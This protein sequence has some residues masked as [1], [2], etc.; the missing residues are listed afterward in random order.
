MKYM[1][2]GPVL[3]A[4]MAQLGYDPTIDAVPQRFR[5]QAAFEVR[6]ALKKLY[7]E[8]LPVLQRIERRQYRPGWSASLEWSH[9]QECWYN[10]EYWRL[11]STVDGSG[12]TEP[13]EAEGNPWTKLDMADVVPYIQFDQAWEDTEMD[14]AGVDVDDFAF[15]GDPK[16]FP[17]AAPIRGIKWMTGGVVLP[18][19]S[20]K[21]VFVKFVPRPPRVSFTE[22]SSSCPYAAGTVVYVTADK[23]CYCA[24]EDIDE[25][26]VTP[27][28]ADAGLWETVRVPEDFEEY[29]AVAAAAAMQTNDQGR[30][31]TLARADALF[32]RIV[33]RF[34]AGIGASKVKTGS[35]G[36]FGSRRVPR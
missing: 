35:F 7:D 28:L 29:L 27:K 16:Y 18:A 30:Y 2:L 21:Q 12:A 23:E 24:L 5:V 34:T 33:E 36:S 26:G 17:E 11:D 13:S 31:Q 4:A 10:D 8:R 15:V 19:G 3:D 6:N 20:P 22:W 9:L 14:P 25:S 32:D 1:Q